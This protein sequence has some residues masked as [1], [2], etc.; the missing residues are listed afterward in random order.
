MSK[1]KIDVEAAIQELVAATSKVEDS[2]FGVK[3]AAYVGAVNPLATT[4]TPMRAGVVAPTALAAVTGYSQDITLD[5]RRELPTVTVSEVTVNDEFGHPLPTSRKALLKPAAEKDIQQASIMAFMMGGDKSSLHPSQKDALENEDNTKDQYFP[6]FD[7]VGVLKHMTINNC[8]F[9]AAMKA[10][11]MPGLEP[12][13]SF[14]TVDITER[15]PVELLRDF[16]A[17]AQ[18]VYIK[19]GTE[20]A[21]QFYRRPNGTYY[22]YYPVQKVYGAHVDY[23]ADENAKFKLRAT[24]QLV[25]EIHSHANMGA[26]FSGGDNDNEKSPC[27]Y[28]VVGGFASKEAK[29]VARAKY[30]NFELPLELGEIFD[31]NGATKEEVLNLTT[32]PEANELAVATAQPNQVR[33]Y[34]TPYQRTTGAAPY[35]SPYAASSWPTQHKRTF[36]AADD[37]YDEYSGLGLYG[38]GANLAYEQ[39]VHKSRRHNLDRGNTATNINVNLDWLLAI[40]PEDKVNDAIVKLSE[41]KEAATKGSWVNR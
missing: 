16:M 8:V 6:A 2:G 26:F 11:V 18:A 17:N 31:F 15:I 10:E 9:R 22:V 20:F 35:V 30:L 21:A 7:G 12:I 34:V 24:D 4:A 33:S 25:M 27:F 37:L 29:S 39:G 23:S 38:Y 5:E 14:L 28:A 1:S 19:H 32:L 3:S 41:R 40:I 13:S 36:E